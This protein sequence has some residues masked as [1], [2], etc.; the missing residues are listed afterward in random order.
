MLL[1]VVVCLLLGLR[2]LRL[3]LAFVL[4]LLPA[5]IVCKLLIAQ[6]IPPKFVL[7]KPVNGNVEDIP[8]KG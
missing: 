3:I 7:Y 4:L 5:I 6:V 8:N 1:D 2:W